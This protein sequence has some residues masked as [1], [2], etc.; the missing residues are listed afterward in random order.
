VENIDSLNMKALIR[1]EFAVALK[2][3]RGAA[4]MHVQAHGLNGVADLLLKACLH[5]QSYD[6]RAEDHR[7]DWLYGMF[8][9]TGEY[10]NFAEFFIAALRGGDDVFYTEQICEL[11]SLMGRDGDT[12]MASALREFVWAQSDATDGITG[13]H[14]LVLLDGIP[15]AVE[16]SRRLGAVAHQTPD[17]WT[18]SLELLTEGSDLYDDVFAELVHLA[19]EDSAIAAY[20]EQEHEHLD[21]RLNSKNDTDELREM[22]R[23]QYAEEKA[24]EYSEEKIFAA[25]SSH[26]ERKYFFSRAGKY[27]PADVLDRIFQRLKVEPDLGRCLRLLW[28]F[29]KAILPS[30]D[31]RLWELA[32]SDLPAV[33]AA[34]IMALSSVKDPAVGDFGRQCVRD[35]SF[36]TDD[37]EVIDLFVLNYQVGDGALILSALNRLKLD[38]DAAHDLC[39]RV[40]RVCES[41]DSHELLA[42]ADWSYHANPCTICRHGHVQLLIDMHGMTEAIASE[43]RH[44]A[45]EDVRELVLDW[46]QAGKI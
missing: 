32:G 30:L 9:N 33:R 28:V 42:L 23:A 19:P 21:Y 16:L 5:N 39:A 25:A 35:L 7:A 10:S 20:L 11:A 27:A 38:D 12:V 22:R 6:R 15:A 45:M 43:C 29:D 13:A 40:E 31:A 8:K 4:L 44:D 18:E 2:N 36:S 17:G 26:A 34:A 37:A 46:E 3:G 24:R 14:A 1:D 41:N